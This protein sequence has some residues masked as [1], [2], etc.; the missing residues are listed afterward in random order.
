MYPS[1]ASFSLQINDPTPRSFVN[2]PLCRFTWGQESL[3][4]DGTIISA[5]TEQLFLSDTLSM[6]TNNYYRGCTVSV[7]RDGTTIFSSLVTSYD[8]S[9]NCLVMDAPFTI[10]VESDD[11]VRLS[12]PDVFSQPYVVLIMSYNKRKCSAYTTLYVCNVTRGWSRPLRTISD[13]GR[14]T[15]VDPLPADDMALTDVF[16][17]RTNAYVY[18]RPVVAYLEQGIVEMALTATEGVMSPFPTESVIVYHDGNIAVFTVIVRNG[19]YTVGDIIEMSGTFSRSMEYTVYIGEGDDTGLRARVIRLGTVIQHDPGL[20]IPS[21]TTHMIYVGDR[22]DARPFVRL[23]ST[24]ILLQP[25]STTVPTSPTFFG[26]YSLRRVVTGLQIPRVLHEQC[27]T[28]ILESL[29]LPNRHVKN[30][31]RLLSFFPYVYVQ[32]VNANSSFSTS[33]TMS[34]NHPSMKYAQFICP[35][36]NIKNQTTTQF[37]E[38]RCNYALRVTMSFFAALSFSVH[39]PGGSVLDY[40]EDITADILANSV[41]AVFRCSVPSRELKK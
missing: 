24:C 23:S 26:F 4:R 3:S 6:P 32:L 31:G 11:V 35:I 25:G 34:T 13:N 17:I 37:V 22:D 10:T 29:I 18:E 14:A 7:I 33:M 39:L 41:V 12:Y 1:P 40:D 9:T 8:A 38:L 2:L 20:S 16:D 28:I 15:L 5:N 36:G 21:P 27:Y 19:V 30:T